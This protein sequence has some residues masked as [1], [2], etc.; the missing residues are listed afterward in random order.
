MVEN[1]ISSKEVIDKVT[2]ELEKVVSFLDRELQKV[3][4]ERASSS[5]VENLEV[6]CFGQKF[7]LKQLA[8]ISVPGPREI[9]IQPWDKSYIEDIVRA[10][11]KRGRL[12]GSPVVDQSVI[13]L[14]TPPLSEEYR[15]EL[16]RFIN[17]KQEEAKKTIRRWRDEAW[18]QLQ[19]YFR[20]GKIREDDKFKGKDKLQEVV[21][22]FL[23]KI[24]KM[25]EKKRKDLEG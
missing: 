3:R 14:T 9:V 2:P 10:L 19:E 16:I 1:N 4:T 21:D 22:D 15:Q 8:A 25:V 20:N 7:I 18:G 12:G 13:R 23:E 6:E 11:E 24:E 17:E 5:L